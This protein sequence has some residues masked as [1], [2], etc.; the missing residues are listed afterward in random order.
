MA[1]GTHVDRYE[2]LGLV[3][4]G[5]MGTAYRAR[6]TDLG[7]TVAL[8]LLHESGSAALLQRFAREA[9][10][11]AQLSHPNV[12]VIY[13]SGAHADVVTGSEAGLAR[14]EILI[15]MEL[16]EGSTLREWMREPRDWRAIVDV[17]LAVGRG[18]AAAHAFGLVHRDVKP[19]NVFLD[20]DG[21][22]KI[23]DFGL[24]A[25]EG[26]LEQDRSARSA[27]SPPLER[28]LT[29]TGTVVGTPAY[30]APE[31]LA[32]D[33]ADA[34]ADQFA[35]CVSLFEALTGRLPGETREGRAMPRPLEPIVRARHGA[36][37]G[38]SSS[39]D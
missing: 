1:I 27:A 37:A 7:R 21:T 12:V 24:V 9:R 16:V 34:R 11:L 25:W 6:D 4:E 35:F 13:H 18:L 10:A 5:G 22:P 38:R 3:G 33:R 29:N 30:M 15:A 36:R 2:I 31:Q 26:A 28:T 17:F 8:K 20:R 23:G 32:G 14:D 39:V 19:S